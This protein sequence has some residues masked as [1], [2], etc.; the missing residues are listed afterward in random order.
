MSFRLYTVRKTLEERALLSEFTARLGENT[1]T[2]KARVKEAA[3]TLNASEM[4]YRYLHTRNL[5]SSSLIMV[6]T[7]SCLLGAL[8][9]S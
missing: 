6:C 5:L 2:W 3:A 1:V 7:S 8:S 4:D 9:Q